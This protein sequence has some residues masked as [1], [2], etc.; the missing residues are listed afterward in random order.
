MVKIASFDI[1]IANLAYCI[2]DSP[3]KGI[4]HIVHWDV[5]DIA[6][7]HVSNKICEGFTKAKNK[8]SEPKKCTRKAIHIID[9]THYCQLHNPD[10]KKYPIPKKRK[11]KSISQE[12]LCIAMCKE[13]DSRPELL[14]VDHVY[15]ENQPSKNPSMKNLSQMIYNYFIIRGIVDPTEPQLKH[16]KFISAKHKLKVYTGPAVV[17]TLKGKYSQRKQLGKIYCRYI[18]ENCE[19]PQTDFITLFDSHGKKD[20]L[21]DCYLQGLYIL[22]FILK[23]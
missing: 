15:L 17:T 9:N 1:G 8:S 11:V 3:E 7:P 12:N 22:K 5:I 20:D 19:T 10:K 23:C 2:L 13:L 14:G 21:A 6:N 18:L 4:Y 16:V